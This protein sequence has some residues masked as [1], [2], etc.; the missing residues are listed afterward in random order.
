MNF[1][2]LPTIASLTK[3]LNFSAQAKA[4]K[5][6]YSTN[7]AISVITQLLFTNWI[8]LSP[9]VKISL[10]NQ[11]FVAKVI[12]IVRLFFGIHFLAV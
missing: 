3:A 2:D 10:Q 8:S 6:F 9:L 7:L 1:S 12:E 4:Q 5:H 11:D